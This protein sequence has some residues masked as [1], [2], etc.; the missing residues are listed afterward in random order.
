MNSI[1][2]FSKSD[3]SAPHQSG[4]RD[5][6]RSH[7]TYTVATH[8]A[9]AALG[10]CQSCCMLWCNW[11][12]TPSAL[13]WLSHTVCYGVTGALAVLRCVS[14]S[15]ARQ[16]GVTGDKFKPAWASSSS[17][18]LR[19]FSPQPLLTLRRLHWWFVISLPYLAH[20]VSQIDSMN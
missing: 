16:V 9:N 18:S 15:R 12:V 6:W 2:F 19:S 11:R 13:A 17:L 14:T 7:A 10:T 4:W 20:M 3:P 1:N 8:G 5:L